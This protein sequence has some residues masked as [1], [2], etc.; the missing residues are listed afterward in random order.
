MSGLSF[1]PDQNRGQRPCH[2]RRATERVC[3]GT[4]RFVDE[5]GTIVW[6]DK[7]DDGADAPAGATCLMTYPRSASGS[8]TSRWCSNRVSSEDLASSPDHRVGRNHGCGNA[9]ASSGSDART[10][11]CRVCLGGF[12]LRLRLGGWTAA[13]PRLGHAPIRP[14]CGGDIA[15][16][17]TSARLAAQPRIGVTACW[18][19]PEG[20]SRTP[21][22]SL[23]RVH[24]GCVFS[25][26]PLNATGGRRAAPSRGIGGG[27]GDRR[28]SDIQPHTPFGVKR[29]QFFRRAGEIRTP[30][31][32]TP[33]QARYQAAPQPVDGDIVPDRCPMGEPGGHGGVLP[34]LASVAIR[35]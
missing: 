35:R 32:L 23:R 10:A 1:P 29:W 18:C 21:R 28:H 30:D 22:T 16:S 14:T 7:P 12:G 8:R 26:P 17:D 5:L 24:I 25:G 20:C 13:A 31:L 3:R 34:V 15:T 9:S 19:A 2:Q 6:S 4:S 33:S 27:I 11:R